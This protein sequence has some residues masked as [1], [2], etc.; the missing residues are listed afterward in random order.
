MADRNLDIALRIKADMKDAQAQIDAINKTVTNTGKSADTGK[1]GLGRLSQQLDALVTNTGQAVQLLQGMDERMAA[2]VQSSVQAARATSTVEAGARAAAEGIKAVGESEAEA[3]ARIRDM[4]AA[5]REQAAAEQTAAAA[6][7]EASTAAQ[8]HAASVQD[9]AAIVQRQNAQMRQSSVAAA[10]MAAAERKTTA[11]TEDQTAA[12]GRLLGQIDPTIAAFERLDQQEA[13]LARFHKAGAIDAQDFQAFRAQIEASRAALNR[14]GVSAGQT[15]QAMR[16]LPA[17]ITDVTVSLA[18]GM[19]VWLVFLQQG[20]QIKDSFGGIKPAIEGVLSVLTPAR[21]A[22]GGLVGVL[23]LVTAGLVKGYLEGQQYNTVLLT[24]GNYAGYTDTQLANLASTVGSSQRDYSDA[25]AAVLAL[26]G[27]GKIT[28]DTMA[29][30]TRATV[31]L[32]QL[33]GRSVK[34]VVNEVIAIGDK[35]VQAVRKLDEQY[36]FLETSTYAQIRALEDQGNHAEAVALAQKTLADAMDSRRTRDEQ[37]LG[38]I[39]RAWKS[40]NDEIQRGWNLLKSWGAQNI[41]QQLDQLYAERGSAQ[42]LADSFLTKNIPGVQSMATARIAAIDKQIDALKARTTAEEAGAQAESKHRQE[43]EAGNAALDKIATYQQRY[44]TAAQKY[45]STIDD[46]NKQFDAQIKATPAKAAELNAQRGDLLRAA[47]ADYAK[48]LQ[49]QGRHP[50]SNN[51]QAAID[52]AAATAQQALIDSLA[53]M[54]GELDPVAAAWVKYNQAVAQ[55]DKQAAI[56]KQAR[57]AN[58]QAIDAERNAIVALAAK[59]RDAA[60]SKITDQDRLAWEKLRDSLR[61][62]TEVRTENAQSQIK[63]LNDLLAKGVISAQQYHDSIQRV[64]D[65]SVLPPPTYSGLD[66]AVGGPY[67]ELMKNQQAQQALDTWHQQQLA[68]NEAFRVTDTANEEAYQARKAAIEQQYATQ[69]KQIEGARQQLILTSSANFF[70]TL[71][72]L[73]NS[74]NAK[75]ARIGKAAAIA[76]AVISTYQSANQAYAAMSGIPYIG[77]ALGAAA[78]AAAIVAGLANVAQ[79]RAQPVGGYAEGGYTGPGGKYQVAGVVHAGEGVLS[80]RDMSA[81]GGPAAFEA[82]RRGLHGY[83]D[84]GYVSPLIGVPA[85]SL[86]A[87]PRAPSLSAGDTGRGGTNLTLHNHNYIDIDEL[88]ER[89]MTGPKAEAHTVNHVLRNGRTVKQGIG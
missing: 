53:Q 83:A 35:P 64:A 43:Q 26:A 14:M 17:Q 89:I 65:K 58:V 10:E 5:S 11:S 68:A 74:N 56:A 2:L 66:A 30:A 21:L 4:I 70:G 22:L 25:R 41:Q 40:L 87:S 59:Q 9:T 55:A 72:T 38:D 33:T 6:T 76:Q 57:G 36:H 60:T 23:A 80:Q 86:P 28:E 79:I 81:L 8:Q 69:S 16:Q 42:N 27:S 52:R 61:T 47:V 75:M 63:Q 37:N 20:S 71:A 85:P 49:S 39:Q 1:A 44:A 48:S 84:G 3:T 15:R 73:Q 13:E 51:K 50:R 24:T 7:Q 19:P 46:I 45:K 78:A 62:P 54:Q 32:A 18:A 29:D 34:D 82:F 12:L 67:S 77:P 88:R 31:A